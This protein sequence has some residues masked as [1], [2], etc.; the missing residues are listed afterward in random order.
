MTLRQAFENADAAPDVV[1]DGFKAIWQ[2]LV[3]Y[4]EQGADGA[5]QP[6]YTVTTEMNVDGRRDVHFQARLCRVDGPQGPEGN[7]LST[8]NF[9]NLNFAGSLPFGDTYRRL[10]GRSAALTEISGPMPLHIK[11]NPGAMEIAKQ[12]LRG[13]ALAEIAGIKAPENPHGPWPW[14]P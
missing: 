10:W 13:W 6:P 3:D 1:H 5:I 11:L 2:E 14:T 12:A 8:R 7:T 9:Y 4:I